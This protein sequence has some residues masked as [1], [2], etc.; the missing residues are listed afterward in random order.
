MCKKVVK[1]FENEEAFNKLRNSLRE[2]G[3]LTSISHPSI[4]RAICM[5]TSEKVEEKN[6]ENTSSKDSDYIEEEEDDDEE[7]GERNKK[8]TS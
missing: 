8:V 5:N 7:R 6:E 4:C 1:S 2:F 3:A